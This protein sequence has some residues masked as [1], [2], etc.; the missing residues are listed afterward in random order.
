MV[1]SNYFISAGQG[2]KMFTLRSNQERYNSRGERYVVDCHIATLSNDL[3]KAIQKAKEITGV[4][5]PAPNMELGDIRKSRFKDYTADQVRA[6]Y[7]KGKSVYTLE[8][9]QIWRLFGQQANTKNKALR[10]V[11]VEELLER[12]E[13]FEDDAKAFLENDN[14][15]YIGTNAHKLHR[16]AIGQ[17]KYLNKKRESEK[18][19]ASSDYIGTVGDRLELELTLNY[20]NSGEGAFGVWRLYSFTDQNGNIVVYLGSAFLDIEK[21]QTVK[22][23]GTI[24]NHEE[25]NGAKQTKIARI[26]LV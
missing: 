3:E 14:A 25:Y 9:W 7:N 19:K 2:Q 8:T 5:L 10:S 26:K 20:F 18:A 11:I 23:K 22:V 4:T 15:R 24:K 16:R 6:G 1:Q 12:F 13:I 21:G 17:I